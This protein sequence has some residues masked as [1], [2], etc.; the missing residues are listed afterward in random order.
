VNCYNHFMF[1]WFALCP[2]YFTWLCPFLYWLCLHFIISF[3]FDY[4]VSSYACRFFLVWSFEFLLMGLWAC[5]SYFILMLY[6]SSNAVYLVWFCNARVKFL[7][8]WPFSICGSDG[9]DLMI[10]NS[11][12][13]LSDQWK[14]Q[15]T[16]YFSNNIPHV[17][18]T[19]V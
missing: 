11:P 8:V 19:R 13:G 4:C 15:V 9:V 10:C 18:K 16:K 12:W 5:F 3:S 14:D 6:I 17:K 2:Y 1:F 7:W